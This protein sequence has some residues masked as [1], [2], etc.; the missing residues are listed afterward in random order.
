VPL[1]TLEHDSYEPLAG[2][3]IDPPW[4]KEVYV[5]PSAGTS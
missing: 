2:S 1:E 5:N 4:T 3:D